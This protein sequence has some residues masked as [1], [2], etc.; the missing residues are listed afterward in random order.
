M[1]EDNLNF[2]RDLKPTPPAVED[3]AA[4]CREFYEVLRSNAEKTLDRLRDKESKVV[5]NSD[6][7]FKMLP[8]YAENPA[9]RKLLGPLLY[10]VAAE[11]TDE[12]SSGCIPPLTS[13]GSSGNVFL[14]SFSKRKGANGAIMVEIKTPEGKTYT[15]RAIS[16]KPLDPKLKR[17]G[18]LRAKSMRDGFQKAVQKAHKRGVSLQALVPVS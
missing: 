2:E 7:L 15:F 11:F 14:M 1:T 10:P 9:E 4:L 5:L 18:Q 6:D 13:S 12:I 8:R 17:E 16:T 3:A